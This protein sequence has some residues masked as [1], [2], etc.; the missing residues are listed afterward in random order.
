MEKLTYSDIVS[1][2]AFITALGALAWNIVRDFISDK[3]G[4]NLSIVFGE[5]GNI[6]DSNTGLFAAA[7]SLLPEHKFD[8]LA[9]LVKVVNVGN[10][11]IVISKVGGKYKKG[12]KSK[13]EFF[14]AVPNLPKKLEPYEV[15]S[16]SLNFNSELL[17]EVHTN[18]IEEFWV[19]DTKGKNWYLSCKQWKRLKKTAEYI[20]LK[21]HL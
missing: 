8:N 6:K 1:T 18:K 5:A 12:Y 15:F 10:K 19:S 4:I 9:T 13:T 14:I 7:G 21:K 3:A 2:L 17:D 20:H 16:A 11:P